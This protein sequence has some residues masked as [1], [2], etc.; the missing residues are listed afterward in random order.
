MLWNRRLFS[1]VRLITP[2][3]SSRMSLNL[4]ECMSHTEPLLLSHLKWRNLHVTNAEF[5]PYFT[6]VSGQCFNWIRLDSSN[7]WVGVFNKYALAISQ[8]RDSVLYALLDESYIDENFECAFRSYL[9][10]DENL[11]TLYNDVRPL[12]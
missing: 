3:S 10:L 12:F 7:V 1:R 11:E 4:P 6:L 5:T 8:T 2:Y 9:Q